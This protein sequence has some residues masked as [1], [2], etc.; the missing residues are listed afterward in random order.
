MSKLKEFVCVIGGKMGGRGFLFPTHKY[1]N[2]WNLNFGLFSLTCYDSLDLV[3]S[4]SINSGVRND[5]I[6]FIRYVLF[7]TH[8]REKERSSWHVTIF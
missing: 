3:D 6:S 2:T 8:W 5:Y 4:G 7:P 1:V